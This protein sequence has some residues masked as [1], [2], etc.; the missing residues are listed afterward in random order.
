MHIYVPH[1][2]VAMRGSYFYNTTT[3]ALQND[4]IR[5]R[6]VVEQKLEKLIKKSVKIMCKCPSVK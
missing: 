6:T 5:L 3:A 2:C 1:S 4:E